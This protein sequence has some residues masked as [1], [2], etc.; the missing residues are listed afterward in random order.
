LADE[1]WHKPV[2]EKRI[3]IGQKPKK[4]PT[5]RQRNMVF[6]ESIRHPDVREIGADG[7]TQPYVN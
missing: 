7:R 3:D 5:I 1:F 4:E 6:E 2:S